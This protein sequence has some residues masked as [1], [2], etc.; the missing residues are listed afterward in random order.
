MTGLPPV[1][2]ITPW[3][4]DAGNSHAGV[5]VRSQVHALV[6]AGLSVRL[7]HTRE[8][9]LESKGDFAALRPRWQQWLR[10]ER[11]RW[12]VVEVIAGRE[13][14][15]ARVPVPR[16]E[17]L[18]RYTQ[19]CLHADATEV[20]FEILGPP[21]LVHAHVGML[22]GWAAA[23]RLPSK[24]PLLITEH[25]S[26][27]MRP[28]GL[29]R[30]VR[31]LYRKALSRSFRTLAVSSALADRISSDFPQLAD[32]VGVLPNIVEVLAPD[33]FSTPDP[34]LEWICVGALIDL[35]RP[36]LVL[37]SFERY[38]Q[39]RPDARLTFVGAGAL[40]EPLRQAAADLGIADAVRF[41][42][43]LPP[44]A[45]FDLVAAS[46]VL[47]HLSRSET[48]SMVTAEALLLGTP[49]V[50]ADSGG[51]RDILD[52]ELAPIS[53]RLLGT[54]PAAD[55]VAA[56]VL[57]LNETQLDLK[58]AA[59]IVADRYRGATIADRLIRLFEQGLEQSHG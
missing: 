30:S 26:A 15:V 19:A 42:G 40:A 39:Q 48:F 5:F 27:M 31:R 53:G 14:P 46:D 32:R 38:R 58:A 18:S 11:E 51:P 12:S 3:Y 22:S 43:A 9:P 2:V 47:V 37:Q 6:E 44:A 54:D 1:T 25:Y 35:K 23:E 36:L 7:L 28:T 56:A 41:T 57:E 24:V 29:P 16:P 13:V 55:E 59:A 45:T 10:Q 50:V 4:P 34:I 8:L 33:S 52:S 20:G 21:Q 49:V 17:G